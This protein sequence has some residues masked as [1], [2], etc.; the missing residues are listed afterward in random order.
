MQDAI[1][2]RE[3]VR[4]RSEINLKVMLL[5]D[6]GNILDQGHLR[7]QN[8]HRHFVQSDPWTI[9]PDAGPEMTTSKCGNIFFKVAKRFFGI[10]V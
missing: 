10:R 3:A 2:S 6:A 5:A 4:V 9:T 1:I 8:D 7:L